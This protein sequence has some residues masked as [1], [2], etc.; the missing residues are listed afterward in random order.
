[1]EAS[2]EVYCHTLVKQVD[3]GKRIPLDVVPHVYIYHPPDVYLQIPSF[4]TQMNDFQRK[5]Y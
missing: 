3:L 5:K 4:C 2:W 1:M